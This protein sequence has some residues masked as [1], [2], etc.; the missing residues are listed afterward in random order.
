MFPPQDK[1]A[2]LTKVETIKTESNGLAGAIADSLASAA[3]H[4]DDAEIQ[5]IKFHG[6]YQQD[7]RDLRAERRKQGLDKAWSYMVRCRIPGGRVTRDQYLAL[8]RLGEDYSHDRSLRLTSR[9]GVQ[10]HGIGRERL[11]Q[12]VR[13]IND[14]RLTTLGACGDVN[15]NVMACGVGDLD[16]RSKL[17]LSG[18]AAKLANHF[19]PRSTAYWEIWCDGEKWGERVT[20]N[21]DEPIYGRTYMPRKFKMA[22]AV[23]EDND[24]DLYTQDIGWEIVHENGNLKAFDVIVGGGMGY[25]HGKQQTYPRLGERAVRIAPAKL[26]EVAEAIVGI[27][28]D[29]GDRTDRAH[30]RLKYVM[31]ERGLDWFKAELFKRLGRE[32]PDAGPMPQYKIDDHLGWHESPDGAVYVGVHIANGRVIDR[33]A[34]AMKTGL[35]KAVEAHVETVCITPRQNVV[36]K[37]VSPDRRAEVGRILDDHGLATN[38]TISRLNRLAMACVALPTCGLA[39]AESERYL[40][41]LI[42]E[43]E[44]AGVGDA[45]VEIRMTG[46]PNSCVRTPTAEIAIVGRGPRKYALYVGGNQQGTRL[47]TLLKETVTDEQL[48]PIIESL[49]VAWR[50]RTGGAASFGDWAHSQGMQALGEIVQ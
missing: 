19:A 20:P 27:Q 23:P 28:R 15:R 25:S 3:T 9:Q 6:S 40:P 22:V 47:A 7:N 10:Y 11:K 29:N 41:G 14:T 16:W 26:L 12:L 38:G 37:L 30:A 33:D 1:E 46:C 39:L 49:I 8:D 48:A 44:R 18:L 31:A 34:A 4:F 24:V 13:A 17:D 50:G 36:L 5:L 45:P 21:R 35:R 43:L 42:A 32:L 2:R